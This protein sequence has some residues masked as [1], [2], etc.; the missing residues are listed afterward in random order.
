MPKKSFERLNQRQEEEGIFHNKK[1][2]TDG[3]LTFAGDKRELAE[4]L[5]REC[6]NFPEELVING[7]VSDFL[8][9]IGHVAE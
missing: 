2:L 9:V 1:L 5:W 3:L 7:S 6:E 4:T 8:A